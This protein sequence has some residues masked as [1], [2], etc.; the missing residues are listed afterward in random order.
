MKVFIGIPSHDGKIHLSTMTGLYA[1]RDMLVS[2]GHEVLVRTLSHSSLVV[3]ARNHLVDAFLKSGADKLFFLD[4]DMLFLPEGLVKV[5][6]SEEDV[7]G[8]AYAQKT[9]DWKKVLK[10]A[11]EGKEHPVAWGSPINVRTLEKP[12]VRGPLFEVDGLPTGFLSI[13]RKVILRL[14]ETAPTEGHRTGMCLMGDNKLLPNL[15]RT[16]VQEGRFWGEDI[17]FCR[18]ARQA[19]FRVW[20]DTDVRVGHIGEMV[21]HVDYRSMGE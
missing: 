12:E 16:E 18:E 13:Q 20:L 14:L 21:Y 3:T 8:A 17:L 4:T 7:V 9:L 2:Q 5:V 10:A 6:S 11:A 1:A 15:F 19:G